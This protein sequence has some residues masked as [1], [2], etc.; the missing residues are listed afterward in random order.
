MHYSELKGICDSMIHQIKIYSNHFDSN[1]RIK[2][3]FDDYKNDLIRVIEEKNS[4][5]TVDNIIQAQ[6]YRYSWENRLRDFAVLFLLSGI[7]LI[8]M[9]LIRRMFNLFREISDDKNRE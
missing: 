4:E 5:A 8:F 1:E 7:L 6:S 2:K 9:L 3:D